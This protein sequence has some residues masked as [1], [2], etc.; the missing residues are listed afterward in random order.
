[1]ALSPTTRDSRSLSS[2]PP[3]PPSSLP[4]LAS[5]SSRSRESPRESPGE[6]TSCHRSSHLPLPPPPD[7]VPLPKGHSTQQ[8]VKVSRKGKVQPQGVADDLSG[9]DD[10][11]TFEGPPLNGHV[12][13][14]PHNLE[15]RSSTASGSESLEGSQLTARKPYVQEEE[16]KKKQSRGRALAKKTSQLFSRRD[17]DRPLEADLSVLNGDSN[18]SL[19][20]PGGS[21]QASY[22]S[23]TS[24]DSQSTTNSSMRQHFVIPHRPSSAASGPPSPPSH[25]R[26]LSQDSH[27]SWQ[28]T[29]RSNGSGASS[30]F[31]PTVDPSKFPIPRRQASNMS[32][33]VPGLSRHAMPQPSG[34]GGSSAPG[35]STLPT[36]MSNWFS[37]LIPST[38][39]AAV[40][41][42]MSSPDSSNSANPPSPMRKP[43]SVATSFLNAARQKAVDGVRHLLDSEAQ[44][45]RCPDTMWVMGVGHPGW[46]PAPPSK[47]PTLQS[48]ALID[49]D[50]S[51]RRESG[52]SSKPSPPSKNEAGLRPSAW[53]KKKESSS[54]STSSPGK[55][56]GLLLTSS[57]SL[58]LPLST[59]SPSKDNPR[60]ESAAES[61][62]KGKKSKPKGDKE[63]LAW[64]EQCKLIAD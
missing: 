52:S 21:R 10:D 55:G 6:M 57:L 34:Q 8:K 47:S 14:T 46:R 9:R 31:N 7:R 40:G 60:R 38:S 59:G 27:S 2:I 20:A 18:P 29:S 13:P 62:S 56:Y 49:V 61:P 37:N 54:S 39:S 15:D 58:G 22:S 4:S 45:D 26:R 30:N 32:A 51:R 11:W 25:S 48:A 33:S 43:P 23:T 12:A 42:S 50:E 24:R 5:T 1:M 63:V 19:R 36:R 41:D 44:P 16:R 35:G 64:P 3:S 17:K 53:T 28:A